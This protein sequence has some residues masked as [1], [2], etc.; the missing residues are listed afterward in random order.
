MQKENDH[1][2]EEAERLE[3]ETARVDEVRKCLE[4]KQRI[5]MEKKKLM[6]EKIAKMRQQ[7]EAMENKKKWVVISKQFHDFDSEIKMND[8]LKSTCWK[9]KRKRSCPLRFL[10][11]YL[12]SVAL[13]L[14]IQMSTG[15]RQ[16][17]SE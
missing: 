15:T 11:G 3:A 2:R 17:T 5:L 6:E 8:T 10:E 12:P 4:E 1:K 13:L 7:N 14:E 16:I 9:S